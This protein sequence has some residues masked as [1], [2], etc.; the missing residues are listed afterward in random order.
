MSLPARVQPPTPLSAPIAPKGK[1]RKGP[2]RAKVQQAR[3]QP[4][5]AGQ[6]HQQLQRPKLK[7][8]QDLDAEMEQYRRQGQGR[9][10][11]L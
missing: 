2:R 11:L 1:M 7:T 5:P 4:A 8:A 3:I 9:M 10:G 6:R